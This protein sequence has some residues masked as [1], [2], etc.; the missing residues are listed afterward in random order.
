MIKLDPDQGKFL[1]VEG[2]VPSSFGYTFSTY[3]EALETS[4]LLLFLNGIRIALGFLV[5][6]GISLTFT[7]IFPGTYMQF[8]S[9]GYSKDA[10]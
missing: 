6:L 2:N 3:D 1:I 9:S 8:K 5:E 4:A 7:T 10:H